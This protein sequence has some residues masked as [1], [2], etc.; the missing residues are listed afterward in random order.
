MPSSFVSVL[1]SQLV[2]VQFSNITFPVDCSIRCIAPP[3]RL[4]GLE[5]LSMEE[6][7]KIKEENVASTD[8]VERKDASTGK[9]EEGGVRMK[10]AMVLD[11]MDRAGDVVVLSVD[12]ELDD[13]LEE[14]AW[15]RTDKNECCVVMLDR[16]VCES[17]NFI[18]VS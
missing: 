8:C 11:A 10:F 4:D 9:N 14:D 15:L 12:D 1:H 18:A 3:S 2:P 5:E 7:L 16:Q 13:S 17:S 6:S